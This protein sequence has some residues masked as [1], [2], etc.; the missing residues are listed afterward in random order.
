MKFDF[1]GRQRHFGWVWLIASLAFVLRCAYVLSQGD[2]LRLPDEHRFWC[3]ALNLAE[4]F[5]YACNGVFAHDMPLTAMFAAVCI[6]LFGPSTMPVRIGFCLVS[7]LTVV[8]TARLA[9]AYSRSFLAGILAALMSSFYPFFIFYSGTVLSETLFLFFSSLLFLH[10]AEGREAAVRSGLSAGLAH[11]ARPTLL[12]FLPVA[13]GWQVV[14]G[15][16]AVS[17]V[18][19]AV[20]IFL[21]V[22]LGW[23]V[24]NQ[25][26]SGHFLVATHS[27]GQALWE[28][29]NPWNTTGGVSEPHW[30]YMNDAPTGLDAVELDRWKKEQALNFIVGNPERFFDSAWKKFLRFWHL[31]PNAEKFSSGKYKW[32][33]LLSFGPVLLLALFSPWVLRRQWKVI[34]LPWLFMA[35]YTVLHMIILGSIRYRLPLEPLLIA[36]GA[37]VAARFLGS[38]TARTGRLR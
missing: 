28:G 9:Q 34:A 38:E 2:A 23:G 4:N 32:A 36:L 29:N 27:S 13:W 25:V 1:V 21:L 10:F 6:K 17:R 26:F 16:A 37:G 30:G 7:S 22:L 3:H 31:W 8:V 20:G 33:S 12:Y 15:R 35:Y 24:R 14:T 18:L 5:T 19:M 11:L